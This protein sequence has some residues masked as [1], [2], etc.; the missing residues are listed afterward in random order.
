LVVVVA[1]ADGGIGGFGSQLAAD[2]RNVGQTT[3]ARALIEAELQWQLGDCQ[4]GEL[5][6]VGVLCLT[7]G[8]NGIIAKGCDTVAG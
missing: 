4:Q 7:L 6:G 5:L 3:L 8:H 2:G 1:V